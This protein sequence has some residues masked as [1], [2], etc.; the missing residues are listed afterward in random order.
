RDDTLSNPLLT[1]E[2]WSPMA[3]VIGVRLTHWA[4]GVDRGPH[5]ELTP[6]QTGTASMSDDAGTFTSGRLAA[7]VAHKGPWQID[8]LAEGRPLTGSP[9]QGM[10]QAVTPEGVFSYAQLSLGVGENVYGLGERFTAF[11]KNGQAVDL[12]NAD[13]GTSSEQTYKNIPFYL[14]NRGYGVFV[15]DPGPVS[16]E[17]ASE[18]VSRVQF[19]VP[20][21][22]LEYFAIYG[23]TPKEVIEKYTALTGRPALPPAWSFGLWLTTSFTTSYD[24]ATVTSFIEGMAQRDLPLAA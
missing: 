1:V 15:N 10:G 12:W 14:T 19:S 5:F 2:F 9:A 16:Y 6:G 24:E 13:A 7:R 22:R 17:V 3:D 21:Q 20:G 11:V 4:G 18:V 23:P 8:F